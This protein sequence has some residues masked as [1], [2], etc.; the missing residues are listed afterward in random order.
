MKIREIEYRKYDK[1][2]INGEAFLYMGR[3]YSLQLILDEKVRLPETKLSRGK[4]CVTSYSKEEAVIKKAIENWYWD[5]AK[6]KVKERVEYY[7]SQFDV[8]PKAS[9][10]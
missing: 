9:N 7:Q 5:K 2:Y 10:D 8:R 3:N 4:L 1:Q 6:E